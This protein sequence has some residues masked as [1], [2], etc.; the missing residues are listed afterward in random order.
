MSVSDGMTYDCF[1]APMDPVAEVERLRKLLSGRVRFQECERLKAE[2]D[3]AVADLKSVAQRF[4][5]CIGCKHLDSD[6]PGCSVGVPNWEWRGVK[7]E[8]NEQ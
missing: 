7:G 3:A 4:S 2:R 6:C 8:A 1:S 5:L